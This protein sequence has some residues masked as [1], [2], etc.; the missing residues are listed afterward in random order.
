M[1]GGEGPVSV[2]AAYPPDVYAPE[3]PAGLSSA[4]PASLFRW[5]ATTAAAGLPAGALWWIAAPGGAFYGEATAPQIWLPR[6]LMLGLIGLGTGGFMGWLV[7]RQRFRPEVA[8]KAAA[9]ATGSVF[10]SAIAWQSGE[11]LGRWLGETPAG[12]P[13]AELSEFAVVSYGVL[14]IWPAAVGVT[15]FAVLLV[16]LLR[17]GPR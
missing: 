13:A 16:S 4:P 9:A 11:A 8:S 2:K 7:A 6:E 1:S 15:V 3:V 14:V 17:T 10:G 5:T 12:G